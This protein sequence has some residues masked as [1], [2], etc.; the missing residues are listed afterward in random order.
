MVIHDGDRRVVGARVR[1]LRLGVGRWRYSWHRGY[2]C[3]APYCFRPSAMFRPNS[4]ILISRRE[5]RRFATPVVIRWKNSNFP[6]DFHF[7]LWFCWV[8][9]TI[10]SWTA[11]RY[12]CTE[13]SQTVRN[14]A[15]ACKWKRSV[16]GS[17]KTRFPTQIVMSPMDPFETPLIHSDKAL[18]WAQTVADSQST[19]YFTL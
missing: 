6:G 2:L 18:S 19:A 4:I 14:W 10:F 8:S 3:T 15:T 17:G 9:L 5:L 16:F 7:I 1:K 13:K 11:R 12:F